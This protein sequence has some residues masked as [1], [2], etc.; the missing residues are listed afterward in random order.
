MAWHGMAWHGRL[1][2]EKNG[3]RPETAGVAVTLFSLVLTHL[4]SRVLERVPG[5][6]GWRV[7]DV[8]VDIVS[9]RRRWN[10][11]WAASEASKK[12]SMF[13]ACDLGLGRWEWG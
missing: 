1:V 5:Y 8:M 12:P 3:E 13:M 9:D 2:E 6:L 4:R 11:R 7:V 10:G